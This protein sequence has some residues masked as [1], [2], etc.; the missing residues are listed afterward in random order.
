MAVVSI[1]FYLH[2]PAF[3]LSLSI[4]ALAGL[5]R[6]S[7]ALPSVGL[8]LTLP[9][10][11]FPRPAPVPLNQIRPFQRRAHLSL[12]IHQRRF[13]VFHRPAL[14]FLPRLPAPF[15]DGPGVSLLHRHGSMR[16]LPPITGY[17]CY[18]GIPGFYA[19]L[20]LSVLQGQIACYRLSHSVGVAGRWLFRR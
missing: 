4:H 16:S 18:A 7:F 8:W 5:R 15:S 14:P 12:T 2:R 19:G 6:V 10:L 11:P 1:S 13:P 9:P 20:R 3:Q 17:G